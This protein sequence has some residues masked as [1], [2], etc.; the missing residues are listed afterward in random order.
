MVRETRLDSTLRLTE[1]LERAL[2]GEPVCVGTENRA[3]CA[4]VRQ[5]LE[6][7]RDAAPRARG[8][9]RAPGRCT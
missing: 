7:L 4:A 1:S 3:K 5:A 6:T 2:A 9:G 8:A